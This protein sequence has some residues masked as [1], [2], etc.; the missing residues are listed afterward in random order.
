MANGGSQGDG[1]AGNSISVIDVDRASAG[2]GRAE[3]AR[4]LV[5]IDDCSANSAVIGSKAWAGNGRRASRTGP[6]MIDEHGNINLLVEVREGRPCPRH[7]GMER[8]RNEF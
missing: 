3:V 2:A 1:S 6:P 4:V 8:F 7:L 5:G